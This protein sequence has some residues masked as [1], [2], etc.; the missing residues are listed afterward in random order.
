[1]SQ[2]YFLYRVPVV[3]LSTVLSAVYLRI[4]QTPPHRMSVPAELS[5]HLRNKRI[6]LILP[7]YL[8]LLLGQTCLSNHTGRLIRICTVWHAART[9]NPSLAEHNMPC[10]QKPTDLDLHCLSLTLVLL[11]KLRCHAHFSF[12]ASQITWSR[13]SLQIHILNCKQCRSRSVG[14][15]RSQLIWI[16]T[17]W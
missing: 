17:V 10:F 1:M 3:Q 7:L 8:P 2:T 15:Y 5:P 12:S 6:T 11:N 14:F 13:L 4:K 9:F 16:Y